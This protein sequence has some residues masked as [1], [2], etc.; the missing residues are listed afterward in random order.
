MAIEVTEEMRA[1]V[2]AADCER[3]GHM[4]NLN[5]ALRPVEAS[6]LLSTTAEV[7]GPNE[8]TIAHLSCNRCPKIW[9]VI[10]D[11]GENYADSVAKLKGQYKNAAD[12]KPRPRRRPG[13]PGVEGK[14]KPSA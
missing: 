2:Y 14:V 12:V 1:A 5:T 6:N 9:L 13:D 11:P 3:L 8:D 10:E 7:G 4:F